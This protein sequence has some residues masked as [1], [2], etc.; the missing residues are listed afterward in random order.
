MQNTLD[1]NAPD[2]NLDA[3]YQQHKQHEL[4]K[5]HLKAADITPIL[6]ALK[7]QNLWTTD[8]LGRSF[9]QRPIYQVTVGNGPTKILAWSQMHGDEPTATASLFDFLCF[10]SSETGQQW[11]ASWR[12]K[13]SLT[14]V[15]M[16]NPDGAEYLTRENAQGIDINRDANQLQSP[17]G[18]LLHQLVHTIKPD[19]AFNLHDQNRY[20]TVAENGPETVLAFMAP[21]ADSTNLIPPERIK[22]MQLIGMCIEKLGVDIGGHIARY[23]DTYSYRAF[24]DYVAAQGAACI[25]VE[26]GTKSTDPNRQIARKMN[27][28]V[29]CHVIQH[30]ANNS[31][32]QGYERN[33]L[34]L[35]VNVENGKTDIL[36]RG[37]S[38]QSTPGTNYQVDINIQLD[39]VNKNSV[40]RALGEMTRTC[41]YF[42]FDATGYIV[43]PGLVYESQVPLTLDNDTYVE[44]MKNRILFFQSGLT[45]IKNLTEFPVAYNSQVSH[46]LSRLKLSQQATFVLVKDGVVGYAVINGIVIDL[47][48]RTA[49]NA[50]TY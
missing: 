49:L 47:T 29:F 3:L 18:V 22:A 11:Y 6:R 41:A 44:L 1:L 33:Y 34:K 43:M 19:I 2:I 48:Q 10:L 24:G 14:L 26:S 36:I 15:P 9:E 32:L 17:E 39:L 25:L 16:L 35:P 7:Q 40:I 5:V 27:F 12:N 23:D 8:E 20:Y 46:D 4:D 21:P 31:E 45:T 37:A 50:Y 28:N 13:I 30:V 38:L 42:D